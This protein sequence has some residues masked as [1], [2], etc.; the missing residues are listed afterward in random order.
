SGTEYLLSGVKR[1]KRV[2][3]VTA[4]CV[5]IVLGVFGYYFNFKKGG[6]AIESVAVLPFVNAGNDPKAE[7]LSDGMSDS[8]IDSLSQLPNLNRVI[9]LSS[10]LRYKGREIDPQAVGRELNVRAVLT[11]RLTKHGD[12]LMVSTELVDVRDNKRL[13]GGQYNHKS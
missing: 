7:Y 10:V 12:D 11:G 3:T 6:E 1:H 4:A 2:A 13:W 5:A 8:L 9:P